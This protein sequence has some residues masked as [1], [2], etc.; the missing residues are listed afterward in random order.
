MDGPLADFD[1]HFHTKCVEMGGIE[2]DVDGPHVQSERYF[3]DHIP[4]PTQ[5]R[6]ARTMIDAAGWFRSLPVVEGAKEGVA[7][8]LDFG[9]D[10]WVCTK[11]LEKNP[12]CRDDKGAWLR[13]HFPMLEDRLIIAPD[14]SLIIG[15]VLLDDAPKVAWFKSAPWVPV[16]FAV[17]FNG[18]GS[19]WDGCNLLR[20]SWGSDPRLLIRVVDR[21]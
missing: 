20:W 19:E 12:T 5:R 10:I 14:K 11:P 6:L 2:F 18:P 7:E 16:L 21:G 15:D 3:T 13:E 4:D 8:L 1:R 17:P 9:F